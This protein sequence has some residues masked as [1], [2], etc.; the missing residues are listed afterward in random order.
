MFGSRKLIARIKRLH[1]KAL[2]VVYRDFNSS[3]EEL[4]RSLSCTTLHQ[5]NLQ[6]LMT[7]I[8]K[9]KTGI[10][11]ELMQ[12]VFE[13]T[14]VPYNL[15]NQSKCKRCTPYTERYGTETTYSIGLKL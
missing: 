11:P 15:R 1:E 13:F 7:E 5:R 3:F 9:V 6:R 2:Q 4:L 12:G 8:F 10:A 14:D